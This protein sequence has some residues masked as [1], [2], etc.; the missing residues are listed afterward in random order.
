MK[1]VRKTDGTVEIIGEAEELV[2]YMNETEALVKSN[3]FNILTTFA[4]RQFYEKIR[5]EQENE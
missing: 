4:A 2:T 3:P 5:E 1:I